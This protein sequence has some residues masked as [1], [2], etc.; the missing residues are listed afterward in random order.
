MELAKA[1]AKLS[2]EVLRRFKDIAGDPFVV[3]D[4]GVNPLTPMTKRRTCSSFPMSIK[5]RTTQKFRRL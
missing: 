5:P 1:G 4:E 3:E 2:T